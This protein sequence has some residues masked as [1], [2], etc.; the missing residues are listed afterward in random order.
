MNIAKVD[1]IR[2]RTCSA[3]HGM[4]SRQEFPE[5][6]WLRDVV[7]SS[8]FKALNLVGTLAAGTHNNDWY[9]N[10]TLGGFGTV[11]AVMV[12]GGTVSPGDPTSNKGS[13]TAASAD[14][15]N[16][17]TLL[18]QVSGVTG[19]GNNYDQLKVTNNLTLGGSSTLMVDE[20]GGRVTDLKGDK[21]FIY[22]HR[23]LAT[24]GKI[25]D[26]MLDVINKRKE[27]SRQIAT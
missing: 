19:A 7:V 18:I 24:N 4:N 8:G 11:G 22:Q 12:A 2:R 10:S 17:G 9:A 5:Q 3:H 13:L 14:F 16:G 21:F 15:S 6:E 20:A 23:L 27:F 26:E 25:H 1:L